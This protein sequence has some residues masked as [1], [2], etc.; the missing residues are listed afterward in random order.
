MAVT[1]NLSLTQ[2]SQN[3]AGNSSQV[4]VRWTSTQTGTSYNM[5]ERTAYLYYSINGQPE[6][7]VQIRYT[8]PL[9]AT[10]VVYDAVLTVPHR[11]DGTGSLS[12]RTWMN[13]NISAG[14]VTKNAS[15]TLT[16][17]PRESGIRASDGVI[18]GVSRITVERKK[19][20]F[21]CIPI[22][23]SSS[24]RPQ[25]RGRSAYYQIYEG[26]EALNLIIAAR[27]EELK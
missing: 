15:L 14:L 11:Q 17:I 26:I 19:E 5:T 22:N 4:Q 8:L 13:T 18:G 27:K 12:V 6:H 10:R 20:K 7:T 16:P 21:H 9:Q 23:Q 3:I 1:Q 24:H 2:L 25:T